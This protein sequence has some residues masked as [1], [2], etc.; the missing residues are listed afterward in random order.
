MDPQT[1]QNPT[2]QPNQQ[3]PSN[4]AEGA[5]TDSS[6]FHRSAA[7]YVG[8]LHPDVNESNLFEIFN[9]VA[10]VAS[11]RVCRHA[12]SRVSLGYAYINFHS[13]P[14][15]ERVLD[16]MNY[17][18]IKG[19]MCRLMWSQRDP[20]LRKSGKGNIY[21]KNL[22]SKIDSKDLYDTFS[23]FGNII[24]CKVV[25]DRK[26][27]ESRGFG[28]VHFETQE[29]AQE[30]I[31]KVNGNVIN[32]KVVYVAQFV[33]KDDHLKAQ[34]WTNLF[35]K[36][37]P[38]VW[39]AEDLKKKFEEF[40]EV[41]SCVIVKDDNDKSKGFGFVDFKEHEDAKKAVAA[42]HDSELE[43]D[44]R[45]EEQI[46]KGVKPYKLFVCRF[47]KDAERK[48][49]LEKERLAHRQEVYKKYLG[50]NLYVRNLADDVDDD[51]LRGE[52]AACGTIESCK[53][54]RDDKKASRGFGFV[55]FST[56]E[57]AQNA[58]R[59][60]GQMFHGKPLYIA[61]WQPREERQNIMQQRKNMPGMLPQGMNVMYNQM[62]PMY[63]NVGRIPQMGRG[64][65]RG[66]MGGGRYNPQQMY[67]MQM[68]QMQQQSRGR[69]GGR[70][71][72]GNRGR[73]ANQGNQKQAPQQQQQQQ[74]QAPQQ[75]QGPLTTASLASA[76]PDQ[77]KNMIG[78]RLYPLVFN[79]NAEKAG[80]ITGMLLD[81]MDTTDLLNL[82]ETPEFL[83]TKIKEAM[84]VLE[85][86]ESQ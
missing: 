48:R 59:K 34:K 51:T 67:M 32:D 49:K 39:T 68:Q 41:S 54:I 47:M 53:I 6:T 64:F 61:M 80:K 50:K 7:L 19:R 60:N 11:V 70:G 28:F 77:Q 8:D 56:K 12:I 3:T 55:C 79:V 13:V 72:G 33:K 20:S 43:I 76:T 27:G 73:N 4:G 42:L 86:S 37:V 69:G 23:I 57:E 82:L 78:E 22:D 10:Q 16:T 9:A 75:T 2:Q 71:R 29:A 36:N 65:P 24:S 81:G 31:D 66:Q 85:Q 46:K 52:F 17:T 45:T 63:G 25:T 74:Q 5:V 26:T 58:L 15:A 83:N 38:K 44:E 62:N 30:A 14:D 21:I 35:A 18:D 40:G 84:D 1:A